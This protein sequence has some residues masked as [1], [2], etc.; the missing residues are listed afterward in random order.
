MGQKIGKIYLLSPVGNGADKDKQ[1]MEAAKK[2][3]SQLQS[4]KIILN[5]QKGAGGLW[6]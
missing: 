2:K 1:A 5:Q 4:S 3:V 6:I